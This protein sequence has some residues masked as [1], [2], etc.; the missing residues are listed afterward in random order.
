MWFRSPSGIG[1][2]LEV[3][4]ELAL[5]EDGTDLRFDRFADFRHIL[6]ALSDHD[7]LLG[8]PLDDDERPDPDRVGLF[9]VFD[10]RHVH[11]DRVGKLL[12]DEGDRFFPD[13]LSDSELQLL[14]GVCILV[15]EKRT[16][17]SDLE[18]LDQDLVDSFVVPGASDE[19]RRGG[20]MFPEKPFRLLDLLLGEDV[21][22]V[23][24]ADDR[25]LQFGKRLRQREFLLL[26]AALSIQKIEDEIAFTEAFDRRLLKAEVQN[27]GTEVIA[28]GV[29]EDQ[30]APLVGVDPL[31][32]VARGLRSL[33]RDR[34]LHLADR[35]HQR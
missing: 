21:R 35:V 22:L 12:G 5:G 32:R 27:P 15:V 4:A 18:E 6:S 30:L 34:D 28:G 33:R 14:V 25:G 3:E 16:L 24:Q 19:D 17:G 13:Q 20:Q 8:F 7:A 31:D 26:G 9:L 1:F 2:D 10:V 23:D 29:D 11:V